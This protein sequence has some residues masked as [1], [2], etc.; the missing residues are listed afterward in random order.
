MRN[1]DVLHVT[2]KD[3]EF[4]IIQIILPSTAKYV[5]TSYKPIFGKL[6]HTDKTRFLSQLSSYTE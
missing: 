1:K 2:L 3:T 4:A 5:I 6:R